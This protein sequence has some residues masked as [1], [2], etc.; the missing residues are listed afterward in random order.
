MHKFV[1]SGE[2]GVRGFRFSCGSVHAV[3]RDDLIDAQAATRSNLEARQ[4]V[5]IIT[6]GINNNRPFR[7]I[8]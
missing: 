6:V 2:K 3:H 8:G 1:D 4:G 7:P 5:T